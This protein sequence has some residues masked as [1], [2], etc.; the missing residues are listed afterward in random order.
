MPLKH[1]SL[2]FDHI[3]KLRPIAIHVKIQKAKT[4]IEKKEIWKFNEVA[5]KQIS[6]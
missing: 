2:F 6:Q 1:V 5:R 4:V 3:V